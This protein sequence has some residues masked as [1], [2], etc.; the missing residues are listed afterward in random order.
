MKTSPPSLNCTPPGGIITLS[1]IT[2][3]VLPSIQH[4]GAA[5]LGLSFDAQAAMAEDPEQTALREVTLSLDVPQVAR[6]EQ[7]FVRMRES[8]AAL[9]SSMGGVVMDDNGNLIAPVAMDVIAS[10]LEQLYD[11]LDARD[12]SAGSVLARRLFS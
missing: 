1:Q 8:A 4:G 2:A 7:P 6:D 3:M 9:A 5:V 11:T 10:E 12:L